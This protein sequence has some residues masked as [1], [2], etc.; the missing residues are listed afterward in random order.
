MGVFDRIRKRLES[1]D[2]KVTTETNF[3]GDFSRS[4]LNEIVERIKNMY[5]IA[6]I[7]D[8]FIEKLEK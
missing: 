2:T 4:I 8:T 6:L 3:T 5:N 7:S 1:D